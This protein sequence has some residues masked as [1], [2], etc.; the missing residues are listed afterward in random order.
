VD[1]VRVI[2]RNVYLTHKWFQ[3]VVLNNLCFICL[4]SGTSFLSYLMV[5]SMKRLTERVANIEQYLRT[6][7]DRD[8]PG[9]ISPKFKEARQPSIDENDTKSTGTF[10]SRA[11]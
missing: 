1:F 7:S 11:N 10:P 3:W 6:A 4:S 8:R 2:I 5:R 9:H